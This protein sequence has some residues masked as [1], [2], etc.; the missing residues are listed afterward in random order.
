M[1]RIAAAA[2]A[3]VLGIALAQAPKTGVEAHLSKGSQLMSQ[4]LFDEAAGEFEKALQIAPEDAQARFQHAVCLLALGRNDEA[5]TE[6]LQVIQDAERA[7]VNLR[8]GDGSR[9]A[10]AFEVDHAA[11]CTAVGLHQR[12][13]R[14][15]VHASAE[16]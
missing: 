15:R 3:M 8:K 9:V 16:L 14:N 11:R 7:L 4:Q 12:S 5:R 6:F 13:Q 10:F 1:K 2:L